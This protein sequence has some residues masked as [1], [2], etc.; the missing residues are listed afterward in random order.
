[1]S[2]AAAGRT[3]AELFRENSGKPIQY[4]GKT[5]RLA[6]DIAISPEH[7]S[8][9]LVFRSKNDE[10]VQGIRLKFVGGK[11]RV[12][13]ETSS[14]L[15]LWG[16]TAP[17]EVD[18]EILRGAKLAPVLRVWNCWRGKRSEIE[19]WVGNSGLVC[20]EREPGSYHFECSDGAGEP[21][22]D[23]LVFDLSL[24]ARTPE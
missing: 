22:F 20:V 8:A 11:L 19:A 12:A 3:L 2:G 7:G 18:I 17:P 14:Q 4:G 9:R 6:F 16:D 24:R 10:P 1:M 5:I 21:S 15:V 13:G 23:A